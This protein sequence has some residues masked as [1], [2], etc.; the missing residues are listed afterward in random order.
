MAWLNCQRHPSKQWQKIKGKKT[1]LTI[2]QKVE[3]QRKN[4]CNVLYI[5]KLIIIQMSSQ[6]YINMLQYESRTNFTIKRE[7]L[8]NI[9]DIQT[10]LG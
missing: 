7:S 9:Q 8:E 1:I 6:L 2:S 5:I 10:E 4:L 3:K